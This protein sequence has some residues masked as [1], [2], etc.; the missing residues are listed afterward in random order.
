[1]PVAVILACDR[2]L[3][4]MKSALPFFH[5]PILLYVYNLAAHLQDKPRRGKVPEPVPRPTLPFTLEPVLDF[6]M[7]IF[8]KLPQIFSS[9]HQL[10]AGSQESHATFQ[11]NLSCRA[12]NLAREPQHFVHA[13]TDVMDVLEDAKRQDRRC[14]QG[15]YQA[16]GLVFHRQLIQS[17]HYVKEQDRQQH[18]LGCPHDPPAKSGPVRVAFLIASYPA[19][20]AVFSG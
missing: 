13:V 4:S 17:H 6:V 14:Q 11:N 9:F 3:F 15:R 5:L 10:L 8:S 2:L 16:I 19:Q 20:R 7:H 1:M 12:D 18:D